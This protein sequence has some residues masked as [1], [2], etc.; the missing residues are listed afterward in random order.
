MGRLIVQHLSLS[1]V[2]KGI[3]SLEF[4]LFP[5]SIKEIMSD[6]PDILEE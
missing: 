1:N 2:P 5:I 6:E 3:Y 4:Q